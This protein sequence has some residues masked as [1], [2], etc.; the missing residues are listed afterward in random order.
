MITIGEGISI[1]IKRSKMGINQ[2]IAIIIIIGVV[3][4]ILG[5]WVLIPIGIIVLLFIIRLLADIFWWG[6]DKEYW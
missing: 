5:K 3:F 2:I 4:T 1:S 6:R